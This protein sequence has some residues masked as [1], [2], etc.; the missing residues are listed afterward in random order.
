MSIS[1]EYIDGNQLPQQTSTYKYKQPPLPTHQHD[2]DKVALPPLPSSPHPRS[3]NNTKISPNK[4]INNNFTLRP[5]LLDTENSN[6]NQDTNYKK[7]PRTIKRHNSHFFPNGTPPTLRVELINKKLSNESQQRAWDHY[8]NT[9]PIR[10]EQ[11][12]Q[13][14]GFEMDPVTG[15]VLRNPKT[16]EPKW[17]CCKCNSSIRSVHFNEFSDLGPGLALTFRL[18][19]VGWKFF[20]LAFLLSSV[21]WVIQLYN[22]KGKYASLILCLVL[23]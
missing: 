14:L 22:P 21:G 7:S 3:N 18:M 9:R 2:D 11:T 20:I 4:N 1:P 13:P 19:Q 16:G 17:S 8:L 10:D 12:D 15:D 5:R 6:D 23:L